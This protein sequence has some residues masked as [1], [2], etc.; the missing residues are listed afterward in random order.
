MS[1]SLTIHHQDTLEPHADTGVP[2][3][4]QDTFSKTTLGFWMY[5]MTDCLLFATLFITYAVLHDQTFGGPSSRQLFSLSTSFAETMILLCS[6]VACGLSVLASLRNDKNKVIAWLAV[7]FLLGASF[8]AI[9]LSEFTHLV[10]E[11][12]SWKRSAFLSS[13]FTLV[14]THGLHIT[15]GLLWMGVMMVQVF[16]VGITTNTFRRLVVFSLFW[17]FLDLIWI[18]IFTFVYLMGVI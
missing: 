18:F 4:H 6:T 16:W 15:I 9:E 12:N 13:F 10:R 8:L 3:P 7:T 1:K 11:G 5:L 17:H 14:G 2:D